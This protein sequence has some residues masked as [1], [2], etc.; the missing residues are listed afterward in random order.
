MPPLLIFL[1]VILVAAG[2]RNK[3]G[4]LF[5]LLKDEMMGD[6]VRPGFAPI[7]LSVG[8]SASLGYVPGLRPFS[9]ILTTLV[10][11][12]IIAA[13][14]RAQ[15]NPFSQLE[16]FAVRPGTGTIIGAQVGSIRP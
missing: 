1:G 9:D 10:F 2:I 15:N 7:A 3:Q 14:V 8:G 16:A 11:V 5:A 4:E 12:T 6:G 13:N